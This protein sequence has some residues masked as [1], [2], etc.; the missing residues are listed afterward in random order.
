MVID[1]LKIMC[2]I[3]FLALTIYL[4]YFVIS[5]SPF[6]KYFGVGNNLILETEVKKDLLLD[7]CLLLL[8]GSNVHMGLSA[9]KLS[10]MSCDA[11]NLGIS[12]EAGGF[13]NYINWLNRNLIA[14]NLIYSPAIFWSSTPL[15][16]NGEGELKFPTVSL[17][18]FIRNIF[19][20]NQISSPVFDRFGDV[21]G[22]GCNEDFPSFSIK[23]NNFIDSDFLVVRE[24]DRRLTILKKIMN[25]DKVYVRVP[26]VYVKTNKQ[27]EKYFYLMS[28]RIEMLKGLGVSVIGNT[29]VSTDRSLFCDSFHPNA[30]G[31]EFFTNEIILPKLLVPDN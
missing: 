14:E 25:S 5:N 20:V 22:S 29:I 24:I 30:K 21:V 2:I 1:K 10:S 12:S 18:L 4:V 28:K 26:P 11:M 27:A 9:E 3:K 17:F 16:D 13:H 15:F 7:K 23:V 19:F 6:I 8:G 31:R